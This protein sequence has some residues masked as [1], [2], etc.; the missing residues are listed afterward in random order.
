M[1]A[2]IF[3]A[4]TNLFYVNKRRMKYEDNKN[5]PFIIYNQNCFCD[6]KDI[7]IM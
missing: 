3:L 1:Q 2:K 5:Y 4:I 7:L 6:I